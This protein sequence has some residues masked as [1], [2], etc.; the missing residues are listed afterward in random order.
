MAKKKSKKDAGSASGDWIVTYSDMVTLML[1][2]FVAL[3]N[4]DEIDP[5]QLAA[6]IS[7]FSN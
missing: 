3:F 4:P 5:S 7:T 6:M 1:C 2:F